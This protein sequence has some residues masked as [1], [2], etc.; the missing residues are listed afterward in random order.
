MPAVK[1]AKKSRPANESIL[2]GAN[3][4]KIRRKNRKSAVS[5]VTSKSWEKKRRLLIIWKK[6]WRKNQG[7]LEIGK[8]L[9]LDS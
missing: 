1:D 6:D 2:Y 7:R 4:W 8:S 9:R 3:G 5:K